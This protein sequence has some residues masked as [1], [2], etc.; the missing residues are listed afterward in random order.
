MNCVLCELCEAPMDR[1]EGRYVEIERFD[2]ER[3][4]GEACL[5]CRDALAA[6]AEE[7]AGSRG[8]AS[9]A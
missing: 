9:P 2:G 6:L 1:D 8:T 7:L 5:A 3:I 4:S